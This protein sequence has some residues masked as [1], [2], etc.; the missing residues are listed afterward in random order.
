MNSRL[1]LVA[2]VT[3]LGFGRQSLVARDAPGILAIQI[4]DRSGETFEKLCQKIKLWKTRRYLTDGYCVYANY[5]EAEK[6]IVLPKT[7]LTRIEGENTRLRHYLAR[8][9]RGT[10]CYTKSIEILK[11]SIRLLM[12]Y[13]R[14][15]LVPIP[16]RSTA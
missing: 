14:F 12:H 9:H 16:A 6:H 8:L 15:K 10:L 2:K 7:Q 4:G 3:K 13:L 1:T 11:C 5:I